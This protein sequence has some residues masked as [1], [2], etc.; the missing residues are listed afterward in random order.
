MAKSRRTLVAEQEE[1]QLLFAL[2]YIIL[3]S[4]KKTQFHAKHNSIGL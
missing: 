1:R 4:S 2:P 3:F